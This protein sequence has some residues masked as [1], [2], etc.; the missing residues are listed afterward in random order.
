[1]TTHKPPRLISQADHDE[2]I[3]DNKIIFLNS[4]F[5]ELCNG[6]SEHLVG[7]H[8]LRK[9][10]LYPEIRTRLLTDQHYQVEFQR[11]M[12]K[13]TPDLY[14][15]FQDQSICKYFLAISDREAIPDRLLPEAIQQRLNSGFTRRGN[16]NPH[17]ANTGH[18]WQQQLELYQ[19]DNMRPRALD[20]LPES[21]QHSPQIAISAIT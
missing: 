4:V 5:Q 19:L 1:M 21:V 15:I 3:K 7:I 2:A 6:N 18:T 13:T 9:D 8:K 17:V 10:E 16:F 14:S 20:V 12:K 11:Q